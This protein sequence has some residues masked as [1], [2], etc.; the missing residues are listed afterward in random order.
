MS[1]Y[2]ILVVDDEK[3]NQELIL[4]M[5][6]QVDKG[7]KILLANNG[8]TACQVAAAKLPDLIIMDWEMPEMTGIEAVKVLKQNPDTHDIPVIIASGIRMS[9]ENLEIALTS[10]ATDFVRKPLEPVELIARV[11]SAISISEYIKQIKNQK[12]ELQAI[13]E[14]LTDSLQTIKRQQEQLVNSEKMATLGEITPIIAHEMNTP[15]S[16]VQSGASNIQNALREVLLDLPIL[17]EA[18]SDSSDRA[19]FLFIDYLQN[20]LANL[21]SKEERQLVTQLQEQFEQYGIE[22]AE[23]FGEKLGRIGYSGTV[24]EFKDFFQELDKHPDGI[25]TLSKMGAIWKQLT[26]IKMASA[27]AF[28]KIN[29]LKAYVH[30]N[31]ESGKRVPTDVKIN[32]Q[33]VLTLYEFYLNQG[34]KITTELQDLPPINALPEELTQLWTN[35]LMNAYH[36]F[37]GKGELDIKFYPDPG[38]KG[39][40]A[41]FIHHSPNFTTEVVAE[42]H[43]ALAGETTTVHPSSFR[44][45]ICKTICDDHQGQ[46]LYS[47]NGEQ[48]I[49]SVSLPE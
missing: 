35:L 19:L 5:L 44:I 45:S 20:H 37:K 4:S 39:V 30:Q 1:A 36:I 42:I 25:L 18:F 8:K 16:A 17:L 22:H 34:M 47:A 29:A 15:L 28:E 41:D 43:K 27:K 7:F 40:K 3:N 14:E 6:Q 10:G 12:N 46:L 33:V 48:H 23:L 31:T 13:N 24:E 11:N 9:P 38:G 26:T 32:M 49:L 2:S 21:S